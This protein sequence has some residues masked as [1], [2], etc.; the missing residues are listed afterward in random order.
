MI[1]SRTPYRISFFGGGTDYPAWFREHGGAVLAGTIDKYC[2][3]TCR[4]LPPFFNHSLRVVYS[5]VECCRSLD[6]ITHPAV[7]ETLRFLGIGGG[8]EIHHDGD[9]PARSGMGSSSSF[10]VGL[11][12]ALH[13]LNAEPVS[14]ERLAS[15]SIFLEQQVL[16]ETVGC[17][18]QV[19]A[20]Y[21]GLN[22]VT[23]E[24]SGRIAV[25]RL[26]IAPARRRELNAHLMLFYTGLQRTASQ[27][28]ASYVPHLR[29]QGRLLRRLGGLV[30]DGLAIL[31]GQGDL[32]DFGTLLHEAWVAKSSLAAQISNSTV[33]AI[34]E[35]ALGA[36]AIGGKLL[37]AGGGGFLLLCVRPE[38]RARVKE[39]LSALIHVPFEF[40]SQGSQIIFRGMAK[41]LAAE[42]AIPDPLRAVRPLP[43]TELVD[44]CEMPMGEVSVFSGQSSVVAATHT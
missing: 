30:N 3:L 42:E 17:Q 10:T 9:L 40:A 21:G 8:V 34:Y 26:A 25:R 37:G 19:L 39:R 32:I 28:A 4:R 29:S 36:G 13:T 14:P 41:D 18:D 27:V 16:H 20:A 12:N 5:Q 15:E 38:D 24:P 7:R 43:N 2:Y 33:D 1:I 11:L 23:F 31:A 22:H 44:G 35:E 6:E